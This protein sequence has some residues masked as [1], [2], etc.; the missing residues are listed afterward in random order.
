MR[1]RWWLFRLIDLLLA[2]TPRKSGGGL[3]IV[4][5]DGVGDM[6]LFRPFLDQFIEATGFARDK[7][8]LLGCTSWAGLADTVFA[9]WRADFIDEKRFEKKFFYRLK[10]SWRLRRAG[11]DAVICNSFFRKTMLHDSLVLATAAPR[12]IVCRPYLSPKTEREFAWTLAQMT[13][14]LDTGPHPTHEMIRHQRFLAGLA[15]QPL[16]MVRF[17][18]PWRDQ[19]P[20]F[21]SQGPYVALNFGSNEP[22]RNWPLDHYLTVARALAERGHRV[23]FV[24]GKREAAARPRLQSAL[25]DLGP[26]IEDQ[27]GTTSLPELLDILKNAALVISNETGPGHLAMILGAPT[28]MIYGGGHVGSFMPYPPEFRH[29]GLAFLHHTMECYGC[30]WLCDKRATTS[31]PFPCV[32]AVTPAEVLAQAQLLL[33]TPPG[34]TTPSTVSP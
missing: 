9:D 5:M 6:V 10:I 26:L 28:L 21:A 13:E 11:Y 25:A 30:L 29:S 27:V 32:A 4:R 3:L 15:V 33:R 22:G 1:R 18:L 31:D 23:V 12:R 14:V 34:L 24:G 20:A 19:P 2:L 16:P 8:T 17:A 7:I